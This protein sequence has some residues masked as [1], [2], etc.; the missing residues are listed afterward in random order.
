MPKTINEIDIWTG[1]ITPNNQDMSAPE[2]NAVLR[3]EFNDQAKQRMEELATR[4]GQGTLTEPESEEL[5]AYVHVGQVI[6]ILQ[7][8]AR[9]SLQRAG[10][11]GSG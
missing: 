2:A 5:E 7:A 6:A 1:V 4:N 10:G 11:N 9:L 3:W 8:K